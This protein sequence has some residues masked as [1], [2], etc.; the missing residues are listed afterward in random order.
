[1]EAHIGPDHP[2]RTLFQNLGRK[3][4]L[5]E[6]SLQRPDVVDYVSDLLTRFSHMDEVRR[7]RDAA[8]QPLDDVGEMLL[9]TNPT[10]RDAF[11]RPER[12]VRRHIGD[13]TLFF[14]GMF[15]ERVARHATTRR[16]DMFV[17]WSSEGRRSYKIV[18]EFRS[19]PYADEAPLFAALSDTY[20]LC[21]I[22]LNR[23]RADLD[24][25]SNPHYTWI[26]NALNET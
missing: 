24:D 23:I 26:R 13:F 18:S 9:R 21:V 5:G 1:M 12:E 14:L 25:L 10:A 2:L 22:G 17:D 8:G 19:H 11:Y 7:V 3:H 6:V 16:P 4:L 15:P 20:E